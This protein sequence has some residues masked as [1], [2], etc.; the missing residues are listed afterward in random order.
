MSAVTYTSIDATLSHNTD[1]GP[2][3]MNLMGKKVIKIVIVIVSVATDIQFIIIHNLK[4]I[5]VQM[6]LW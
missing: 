1:T 4:T 3:I 5:N 2:I 6:S